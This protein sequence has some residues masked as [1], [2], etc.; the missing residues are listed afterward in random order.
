MDELEVRAN[1]RQE[2][3]TTMLRQIEGLANDLQEKTN[4]V[5]QQI[6]KND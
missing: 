5:Q 3:T 6:E 1:D 4:S 2:K